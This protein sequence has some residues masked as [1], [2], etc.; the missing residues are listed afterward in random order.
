MLLL[1]ADHNTLSVAPLSG[2]PRYES[3]LHGTVRAPE[4]YCRG[5]WSTRALWLLYNDDLCEIVRV[6]GTSQG[7]IYYFG[8]HCG[9]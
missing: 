8:L 4:S 1:A 3:L 7:I 2:S 9:W 6:I 5:D